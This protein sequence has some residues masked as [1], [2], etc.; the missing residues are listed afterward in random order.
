[1]AKFKFKLDKKG[2]RA[3]LSSE[4]MK[5]IIE[6]HGNNALGKCDKTNSKG[7]AYKYELK[8]GVGRTRVHANI[9]CGDY[10][11]YYHNLKTNTLIKAIK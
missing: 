2:V 4:E 7:E 8:V 11:A 9:N 10:E 1:M 3:L 6:E 5:K